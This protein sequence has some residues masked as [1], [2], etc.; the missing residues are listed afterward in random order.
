MEN[1]ERGGGPRRSTR[2]VF[3]GG[4]V[5]VSYGVVVGVLSGVAVGVLS[6][7]AVGVLSGVAVGPVPLRE[8]LA[9]KQTATMST[10][11]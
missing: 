5:G 8:Q 10:P 4:A 7:V 6:G 2:Y 1:R 9:I 3:Y 11:M